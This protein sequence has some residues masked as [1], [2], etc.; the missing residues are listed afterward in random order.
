VGNL[1]HSDIFEKYLFRHE[2]DATHEM[3]EGTL[4]MFVYPDSSVVSSS[5]EGR[6][7]GKLENH[8]RL[9]PD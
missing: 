5:S 4:H 6:S 9:N 8:Y 7:S 3:L 2:D 1:A